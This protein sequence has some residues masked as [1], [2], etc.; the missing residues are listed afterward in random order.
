MKAQEYL[1][2]VRDIDRLLRK[3]NDR[4]ARLESLSI[5]ASPSFESGGGA[6]SKSF[7]ASSKVE[8][9]ALELVS[10]RDKLIEER[11]R[12]LKLRGEISDVIRAVNNLTYQNILEE[13]YLDCKSFDEIADDFGYSK[14][15][16]FRLHREALGLVHVPS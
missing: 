14:S 11:S 10:Q 5:Y 6:G 2:Q 13:R 8:H 3:T 4:I 12:L 16:V 7:R 15:Y 9:Y 1:R